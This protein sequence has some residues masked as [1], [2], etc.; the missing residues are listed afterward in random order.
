MRA[1]TRA[2]DPEEYYTLDPVV[3]TDTPLWD[4]SWDGEWTGGLGIGL[5]LAVIAVAIVLGNQE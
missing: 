1:L 4:P 3:V 5:V 2:F